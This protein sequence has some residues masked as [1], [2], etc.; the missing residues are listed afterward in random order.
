[1]IE[2]TSKVSIDNYG[3]SKRTLTPAAKYKIDLDYENFMAVHDLKGYGG[4]DEQIYRDLFNNGAVKLVFSF[5]AENGDIGEKVF[6]LYDK[7]DEAFRPDDN[8]PKWTVPY[9]F[10]LAHKKD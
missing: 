9:S 8:S 5:V 7:K 2:L 1:M 6:Y 4:I 10:F 3:V